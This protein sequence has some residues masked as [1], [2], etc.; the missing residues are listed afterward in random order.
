MKGQKR[1]RISRTCTLKI[2]QRSI[3]YYCSGWSDNYCDGKFHHTVSICLMILIHGRIEILLA[4]DVL[5]LSAWLSWCILCIAQ[6]SIAHYTNPLRKRSWFFSITFVAHDCN[7][8]A[9]W[10]SWPLPLL[11][12]EPPKAIWQQVIWEWLG[13]KTMVTRH[14]LST[15]TA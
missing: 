10:A 7:R 9:F 2:D 8:C 15:S 13:N 3:S 1:C 12:S 14:F 5:M 11:L 4:T 6:P